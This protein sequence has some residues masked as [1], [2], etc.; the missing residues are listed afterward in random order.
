MLQGALDA[1]ARR[2]VEAALAV[3]RGDE[4]IDTQLSGAMAA[5]ADA[6]RNTPEAVEVAITSMWAL[7]SLERVG[8]HARN[9]AEYVIY[10]VEG[11]DVRHAELDTVRDWLPERT[12]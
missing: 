12:R 7:R 11:V 6:M 4:E 9:I 1:F 8:D 10:M 5:L 2:N 3:A